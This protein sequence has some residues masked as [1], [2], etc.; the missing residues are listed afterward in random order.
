[1][2]TFDKR[3]ILVSKLWNSKE[4]RSRPEFQKIL[5]YSFSAYG[6][7]SVRFILQCEEFYD[8]SHSMIVLLHEVT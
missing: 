2:E 4:E 3:L 6:L 5:F 7:Q 8:L 1:M